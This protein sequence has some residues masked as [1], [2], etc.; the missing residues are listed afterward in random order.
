MMF[1]YFEARSLVGTMLNAIFFPLG[2][3]ETWHQPHVTSNA[4][5]FQPNLQR[6]V[7]ICKSTR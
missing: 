2:C 4:K 7:T 6:V 1:A 5:R 3:A